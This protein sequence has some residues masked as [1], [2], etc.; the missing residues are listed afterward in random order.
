MNTEMLQFRVYKLED[1]PR[2]LELISSC[3]TDNGPRGKLSSLSIV[4]AELD[5]VLLGFAALETN[6]LHNRIITEYI[7]VHADYRKIGLGQKLH[8]Y[9]LEMYPLDD[10]DILDIS[11]YSDQ[12]IEQ[13]FIEKIGFTKY[14]NC[15]LNLYKPNSIVFKEPK[16]EVSRLSEFYKKRNAKE[17]VKEF[18]IARYSQEHDEYLSV[19]EGDDIWKE[20]FDDGDPALSM[21]LHND[22]RIYATSFAYLDFGAEIAHD[23]R[24]IICFNGYAI[25]K[26]AQEE[27]INLM[28]LYSH[29]CEL[30][31]GKE[32]LIYTEVDSTERVSEYMQDWLPKCSKVYERY[33]IKKS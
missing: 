8:N 27:A 23:N 32:V 31:R 17:R 19:S 21:V 16:Y 5:S 24:S 29:Q 22:D 1:E 28:S 33:Q 9:L 11:C 20:Y 12:T 15:Y 30:V 26:D 25:G 18:H 7:C 14:L 2:C 10:E 6:K 4:V 3:Y 13:N